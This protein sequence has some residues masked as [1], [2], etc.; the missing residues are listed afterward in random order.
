MIE[1]SEDDE[2]NCTSVFHDVMRLR[3]TLNSMASRVAPTVGLQSTEMSALDT[4]GKFGPLTMGQLAKRSF[5]SP[6]NTTRTVK[7][8]VNRELVERERSPKSDRE[9]LVRLTAAGENIFRKTYPHMI[10]DVNDLLGS[11]RNQEERRA[12]ATLLAKLVD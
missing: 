6:T 5:I 9:V 10:H 1:I 7:N 2:E 8:L 3:H 4:L 11:K 12:F